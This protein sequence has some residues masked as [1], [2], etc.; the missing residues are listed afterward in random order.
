M[1]PV[2]AGECGVLRRARRG[3][4]ASSTYRPL[5]SRSEGMA[6]RVA[7]LV[8]SPHG[9]SDDALAARRRTVGLPHGDSDGARAPPIGTSHARCR[10]Y[11]PGATGA[12]KVA[13]PLLRQQRARGGSALQSSH[14]VESSSGVLPPM[15]THEGARSPTRD[16]VRSSV[17]LEQSCETGTAA[18]AEWAAAAV[19]VG[20]SV[21]PRREGRVSGRESG[22]SR[23]IPAP[24]ESRPARWATPV[25][26]SD[27]ALS[28]RRPRRARPWG[29]AASQDDGRRTPAARAS[30]GCRPRA[31]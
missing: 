6:G 29:A 28:R 24:R 22:R 31:S 3:G 11:A 13:L 12:A 27:G 15:P 2:L 14:L 23:S 19:P 10:A 17:G 25:L 16:H 9:P 1:V 30:G 20:C 4:H 18:A 5:V 26:R 8:G 21:R 7:A